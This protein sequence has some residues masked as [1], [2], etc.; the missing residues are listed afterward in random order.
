MEREESKGSFK[1][2]AGRSEIKY[3]TATTKA[4]IKD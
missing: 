4:R 2:V 3:S 1:Q